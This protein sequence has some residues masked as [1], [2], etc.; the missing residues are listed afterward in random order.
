MIGKVKSVYPAVNP[1]WEG[2]NGTLY[3]FHYEMEDGTE[4]SA[5]HKSENCPFQTGDEVEYEIKGSNNFGSWGKVGK[6]GGY[7][8]GGQPTGQKMDSNTQQRIERSW[9]MGHAVQMLGPLKAVNTK[10]VKTYMTEACRLA[11]ILLK[12]R[13]TFPKFEDDEVVRSYWES[14]AAPEGDLPF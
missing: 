10:S 4:L 11:D 7:Q 6:V 14:Q 5:N 8:Q 2:P 9:A 12:A 1:R 3:R 13:D